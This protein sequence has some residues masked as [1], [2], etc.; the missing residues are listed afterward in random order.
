MTEI[1]PELLL[2]AYAE[3][4]FPMAEDR[5]DTKLFWVDPE[6]RGVLPLDAFHIPK[7]LARRI[8]RDEF[9]FSLNCAFTEVIR[10][11]ATPARGRQ[12][13]WISARIEELYTALHERANAHSIECWR[14]GQL[15]GGLYGVS[16]GAGFFGE[17]MF[18]RE[19]DASK[20]A[21]VFLVGT[22]KHFN[23]KLLDTQFITDHLVQFGA[24]EIPRE[25]YRKILND[26][27]YSES[28]S[29]VSLLS[30]DASWFSSSVDAS[31]SLGRIS[32]VSGATL[33]QSI[34][35]TS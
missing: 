7:R 1:T 2:G 3:G 20:A 10:S 9:Q 22:L 34:S 33:L 24:I 21:L 19:T 29:E 18:S 4:I 11:C 15:V 8:R 30:E 32:A 6:E 12:S 13:T 28:S 25:D 5:H 14:E 35:Q 31:S 23:F 27:V 26:A 17:S 16:L